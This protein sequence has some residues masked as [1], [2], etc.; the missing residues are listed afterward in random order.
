MHPVRGKATIVLKGEKHAGY[1]RAVFTASLTEA[2]PADPTLFPGC[3]SNRQPAGRV[4]TLLSCPL[5]RKKIKTSVQISVRLKRLFH[6]SK[7]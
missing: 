2:L 3:L 4:A 7:L 1:L 6:V 5:Q